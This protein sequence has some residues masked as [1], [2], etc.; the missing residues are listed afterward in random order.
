MNGRKITAHN[1]IISE[2][3]EDPQNYRLKSSKRKVVKIFDDDY[4]RGLAKILDKKRSK[5]DDPCHIDF[6]SLVT[7][8]DLKTDY[9]LRDM[10]HDDHVPIICFV[11]RKIAILGLQ[12]F[13]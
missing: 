7:R 8:Y 1:L 10:T 13:V 4:D 12:G 3:E 9:L 11:L 6:E 2:P 5:E